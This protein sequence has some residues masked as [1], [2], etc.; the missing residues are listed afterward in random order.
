MIEIHKGGRAPLVGNP[1]KTR[2]V[3]STLF[4][5]GCPAKPGN[6]GMK[7]GNAGARN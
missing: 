7:P 5:G 3:D 4:R 2:N 1:P 6:A